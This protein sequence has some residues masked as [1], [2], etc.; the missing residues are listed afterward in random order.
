M[1]R[2]SL[3]MDRSTRPLRHS[4]V[5]SSM[6]ETILTGRPSVVEPNWKSTARTLFGASAAGRP[7]MVLIPGRLR[8]RPS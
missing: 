6:I 4:R 7:V 5:R 1:I 2:C 3:V 8:R